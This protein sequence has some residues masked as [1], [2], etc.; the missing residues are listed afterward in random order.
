MPMVIAL[1]IVNGTLAWRYHPA[2]AAR[3]ATTTSVP[4]PMRTGRNG[5]TSF[6]GV[7]SKGG[8]YY[9]LNPA[10]GSVRWSTNVVFGGSSGD[11]IGTTAYDGQRIYGATGLGDFRP[12]KG[13]AVPVCD[14]SDSRD[15]VTQNPTDHAFDA[16]SGAVLW[17]ESGAASFDATTVAGAMTFNGPAL[18]AKSVDVRDA[19]TG[20]LLVRVHLPQSNWSGVATVGNAVVLGLG[21][22]FDPRS[23][24]VM[25]LTPG[26]ER[27]V[28]PRSP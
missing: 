20:R 17:Q 2:T 4:A 25:V 24:G 21:S 1:H 9:S 18:A 10:T 14:P 22:T 5:S 6:L 27:P 3:T 13:G 23:A 28:V 12:K 7:G 26:G 19:A 15:T 11:F 8:T 16:R